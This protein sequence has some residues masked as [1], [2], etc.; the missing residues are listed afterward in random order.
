[1]SQKLKEKTSES[2]DFIYSQKSDTNTWNYWKLRSSESKTHPYPDDFDDTCNALYVLQALQNF[3]HTNQCS[4]ISN[5]RLT[6]SL[7]KNLL[8]SEVDGGYNTWIK[9][10]WQDVDPVVQVAIYRILKK[11]KSVPN[12]LKELISS[13]LISL[14]DSLWHSKY[15]SDIYCLSE[16]SSID[17]DELDTSKHS[18]LAQSIQSSLIKLGTGTPTLS[19]I[20]DKILIQQTKLNLA[21][22][23]VPTYT[24]SINI[25]NNRKIFEILQLIRLN[26]CSPTV[27]DEPI[28]I[29]S[30][31]NGNTVY[32]KSHAFI[33]AIYIK[34]LTTIFCSLLVLT[35]TNSQ[36][37]KSNILD[38]Q[39]LFTK[40]KGGSWSIVSD[41]IKDIA[42]TTYLS[43][44][45]ILFEKAHDEI[46]N[47]AQ[48]IKSTRNLHIHSVDFIEQLHLL[49]TFTVYGWISYTLYDKIL[50]RELSLR[51]LPLANKYTNKALYILY[52]KASIDKSTYRF[53][54]DIFNE[55][56]NAE[57]N[58]TFISDDDTQSKTEIT[59]S[60]KYDYTS[61]ATGSKSIGHCIGLLCVFAYANP[62]STKFEI[63]N[64]ISFYRHKLSIK[65]IS[66]DIHDWQDDIQ[67]HKKTYVTSLIL[68][69]IE[70]DTDACMEKYIEIF[71]SSIVY[72][73]HS[74]M[75]DHA[76]SADRSLGIIS[77][78]FISS[79]THE[80]RQEINTYIEGVKQMIHEIEVYNLFQ[81]S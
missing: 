54:Q 4:T 37:E 29:E 63:E 9:S 55:L 79:Y 71:T 15:Y 60:L 7:I 61:L 72:I 78:Y 59:T 31:H 64:L 18:D 81:K 16:L 20:L 75:L 3:E 2:L 12:S 53:I 28:F 58:T 50:D 70:I 56:H 46:F 42:S 51:F 48:A 14:K 25:W 21:R 65:Q 74:A 17:L 26:V 66:D 69:K 27:K 73:A 35:E 36:Y 1:M 6:H 38:G 76:K 49:S 13:K 67:M 41:A 30:I 77:K 22:Q 45:K 24:E 68:D 40:I 23:N 11:N 52:N 39:H 43:K 8:D 62:K 80:Q 10:T 19:P 47:F 57:Q 44:R 32:C 5:A 34:L 33:L